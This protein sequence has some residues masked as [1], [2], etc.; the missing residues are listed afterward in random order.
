MK[1]LF[2]AG[3]GFCLF[4]VLT[5]F[6]T[7]VLGHRQQNQQLSSTTNKTFLK[8]SKKTRQNT[9]ILLLQVKGQPNS[10][11]SSLK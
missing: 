3:A 6:E 7:A 5:R 10:H 8:Q 1:T 4:V 11:Y 2:H 9:K